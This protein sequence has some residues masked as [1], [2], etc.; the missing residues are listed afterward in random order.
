MIQHGMRA[1][2]GQQGDGLVEGFS[3]DG[4]WRSVLSGYAN[5]SGQ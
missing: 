5:C 2:L 4:E 1:V 3:P